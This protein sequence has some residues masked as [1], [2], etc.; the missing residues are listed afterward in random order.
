MSGPLTIR[1]VVAIRCPACSALPEAVCTRADR[2]A[3]QIKRELDAGLRRREDLSPLQLRALE[4]L[5][6]PLLSGPHQVRR[7]RALEERRRRERQESLDRVAAAGLRNRDLLRA[8]QD[9]DRREHDQ[10]RSWLVDNAPL[11]LDLPRQASLK[12]SI[13]PVCHSP[14][15]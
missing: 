7:T 6:K 11:F 2:V 8:L 13:D 15:G 3:A 1:E 5:G 4:A 9:H 12:V 10:L 14:I